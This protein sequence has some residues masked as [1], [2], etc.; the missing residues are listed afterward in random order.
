MHLLVVQPAQRAVDRALELIGGAADGQVQV[1]VVMADRDR[2]VTRDARL[3]QA[4]VA[5][6]G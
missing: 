3:E 1:A 6:I 5:A 4:A 2:L